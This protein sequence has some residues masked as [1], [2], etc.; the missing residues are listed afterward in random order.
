MSEPTYN[1]CI[2]AVRAKYPNAKVRYH[3]GEDVFTLWSE[4]MGVPSGVQLSAPHEWQSQCWV[5]VAIPILNPPKPD[6]KV[7]GAVGYGML[8]T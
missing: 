1:D 8:Q 2:E 5:E 4:P 7:V 3:S 6:V